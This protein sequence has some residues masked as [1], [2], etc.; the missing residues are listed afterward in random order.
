[1]SVL[2]GSSEQITPDMTVAEILNRWPETI[3]VFLKYQTSCVGCSMA[4][5]ETISDAAG[6][7]HI[8]LRQFISEL[9]AVLE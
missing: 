7:Y 8:P 2:Q 4:S 5:F 9:H 6:I 3:P 1:M